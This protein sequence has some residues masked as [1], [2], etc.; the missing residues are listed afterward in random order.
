MSN[1]KLQSYIRYR[2]T[3]I[4]GVIAGTVEITGSGASDHQLVY[5]RDVY[6][7]T[8]SDLLAFILPQRPVGERACKITI[9][10]VNSSNNFGSPSASDAM[11]VPALSAHGAGVLVTKA[12]T[13]PVYWRS[14]TAVSVDATDHGSPGELYD[15]V[16][17]PKWNDDDP[18]GINGFCDLK[19]VRSSDITPGATTMPIPDRMD[20]VATSI[21]IRGDNTF[22]I[23]ANYVTNSYVKGLARLKGRRLTLLM[24]VRESG[25]AEV[26]EY[27]YLVN[28]VLNEVPISMPDNA[29]LMVNA[30]GYF[31]KII[32]YTP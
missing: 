14:V 1:P 31:D 27:I 3:L 23:S 7:S 30:T 2:Y 4:Q 24:E 16:L 10:G 5:N 28:A 22:A 32:H 17:V 9:T 12:G 25:G 29:E 26:T 18:T 6:T 21:A 11:V 15:I 20:A 8:R 13:D 19:F